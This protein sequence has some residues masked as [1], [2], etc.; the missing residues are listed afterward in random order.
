MTGAVQEMGC[1]MT[2]TKNIDSRVLT[3]GVAL[4]AM[5]WST[6]AAAQD[7]DAGESSSG[8][9]AGNTIIVTAQR[10]EQSLDD[11]PISVAAFDTRAMDERGVRSID[12]LSQISPGLVI[13]RS[14]TRN[15][16][17]ARISIRGINSSAGA[18][19]T[20]IYIDD[21]PIQARSLGYSSYSVFPQVFDLERVEVLRGPQ[22]TLFGAGAQ[23]G[24]VRFITP[25]PSLYDVSAYGR[26][27]V[28]TT[29]NGDESWE[30]GAAIGVPLI[31]DKLALR[32][33][34]WH[35]TEGGYV[36]RM[37]YDR[38]NGGG[39]YIS[40]FF[41]QHPY[42]Q[43]SYPG[44]QPVDGTPEPTTGTIVEEDS[45]YLETDIVR[46]AL[47]FTPIEELNITASVFYQNTYSNDSG[48]YWLNLSDVDDRDF[49]QGNNQAQPSS[50]E[51]Y[52]PALEVE[53]DA[54]PF[55]IISN[56]SFFKR[57][58]EAFNDYTAFE[59]SLYFGSYLS[60]ID[61][62]TDAYQFNEQENFTQELRF[63]SNGEGP[64]SWVLGFFYT[65]NFQEARQYNDI[66]T[67]PV[68][69]PSQGCPASPFPPGFVT[70]PFCYGPPVTGSDRSPVDGPVLG[71]ALDPMTLDETQ[72]AVFA[73]L[74]YDITDRLTLTAGLRVAQTEVE[75]SATNYGPIV[76]PTPVIAEAQQNETPITPKFG[77]NYQ[78]NDDTL[79]YASIAKGFRT[80]GGNPEIGQGCNLSL[81]NN[82][83]SFYNS[84]SLWSY[85]VGAKAGFFDN[86]VRIN[87]SG[88]H[89]DWDNIQQS[90]GLPCGFQ[91][92]INGGSA[93]SRGF[94]ADIT[95]W[96][97]DN[98]M[99]STAFGYNHTE[100]Q[101]NVLN[102]AGP[103]NLLSEGDR[104]AGSPWQIA[105]SAM[106]ELP[107][108]SVDSY[109]RADWNYLSG[110][111][112][113]L[114]N[115]N[116]NNNSFNPALRVQP[117]Y[118]QVNFRAGV[119]LDT[120]DLSLFV[121]NV[122]NDAPELGFSQS[123]A[124]FSGVGPNLLQA[125]TLRPRTF[126]LTLVGRY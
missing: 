125:V 98:L 41:L 103:G 121:R 96:A 107:L 4:A 56:T 95:V 50:D 105:T 61:E 36:D 97:T 123:P 74:D 86:R 53:Y 6:C 63:Q 122:F 43:A 104:V 76:G 24:A 55:S 117:G 5:A 87:A 64:L 25:A 115:Q 3:A 15:A 20:G 69:F 110:W 11:V 75:I 126:G 62:S 38:P 78:I 65:D 54:G 35:R 66:S 118:H 10:Q 68:P 13:Q 102:P 120:F 114:I 18:A 81:A 46:A 119:R 59:H 124:P 47:R 89:I 12:D 84:D 22:G 60:D 21:V 70:P 83:L 49:V 92:V 112:D 19:T 113:D 90:I 116:P 67:L 7:S 39:P 51:F 72:A 14:D 94:D 31:E 34:A 32:V 9:F 93:V 48:N 1:K 85:E 82:N 42:F 109:L 73:Q 100:F 28:S 33:S 26:A 16:S 30:V 45:N 8:D 99:L 27:E 77:L 23:G 71:N 52:I 111:P 58:Q 17:A 40:S 29:E 44:V 2:F 37:M 79:V 80:G 106:Y 101:E 88:Y 57:D 91:F 108:G